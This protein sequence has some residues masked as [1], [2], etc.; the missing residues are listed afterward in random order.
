MSAG[1]AVSIAL[2]FIK[3]GFR[4]VPVTFTT[5][6]FWNYF[7][8]LWQKPPAPPTDVPL[9]AAAGADGAHDGLLR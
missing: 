1:Q 9:G 6:A 4:Y 3:R 8:F 5:L 7:R 2:F